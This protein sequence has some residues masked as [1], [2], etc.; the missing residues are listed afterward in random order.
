MTH[1]P[2]PDAQT[3][4]STARPA[5]LV[6][7]EVNLRGMQWL[8]TPLDRFA[9]HPLALQPCAEPF[10]ALVL[11]IAEAWRQVPAMS[12]PD[13]DARLA[14]MA[15][16]GR[17]IAAWL[18]VRESVL[19]DWVLSSDGNFHHPEFS[20]WGLHSWNRLEAKERFS[21]QQRKRALAGARSRGAA[22]AQPKEE[23][24][25]IEIRDGEEGKSENQE[26]KRVTTAEPQPL[27]P[28][29][30]G[31]N[32]DLAQARDQEV[33][34]EVDGDKAVE[35][36]FAHWKRVTGRPKENLTPARRRIVQARLKEDMSPD[37][38]CRAIDTASTDDFYMGRTAKQPRRIDTL[39]VILKDQDRVLRL[40]SASDHGARPVLNQAAAATARTFMKMFGDPS[41]TTIETT[42]VAIPQVTAK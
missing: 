16:F 8:P 40:A 17:D 25:E 3:G 21:E 37:I 20:Q 15:G 18:Q 41:P 39:D 32:L 12:L 10:R 31:G 33:G 26:E 38:L 6:P 24:K 14:S 9:T 23:D 22:R 35:M 2:E 34:R 11:L 5:P 4:G 30:N 28:T 42:A 27:S 29:V 13:N 36:V 19:S 7:P 1:S